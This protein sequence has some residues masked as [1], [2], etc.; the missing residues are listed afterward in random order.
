ML[1]EHR[2][3]PRLPIFASTDPNWVGAPTGSRRRRRPVNTGAERY[4]IGEIKWRHSPARAAL[5]RRQA[6]SGRADLD[7]ARAK[8]LRLG[9]S[10]FITSTTSTRTCAMCNGSGRIYDLVPV[11][12]MP[13]PNCNGTG[14]VSATGQSGG[15]VNT[16]APGSGGVGASEGGQ[17]SGEAPRSARADLERAKAMRAAYVA[18]T[19][20]ATP[21]GKYSD[22]EIAALGEKGLALAKGNGTYHYPI[23][24][25]AD[26]INALV[27]YKREG[28]TQPGVRAWLIKRAIALNA[29]HHLPKGWAEP[30]VKLHPNE[31]S[32]GNTP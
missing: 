24:D 25:T 16:E 31:I 8:Q 28:G 14:R 26:L 22:D 21:K 29:T 20:H 13:C 17:M 3:I 11:L 9:P 12:G 5:L 19:V 1:V 4:A 15:K 23:V 32:A 10:P 6:S 2:V 27:A 30:K 7:L 18:G